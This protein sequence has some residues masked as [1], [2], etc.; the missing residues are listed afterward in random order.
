MFLLAA[1][2]E[3]NIELLATFLSPVRVGCRSRAVL[4]PSFAQSGKRFCCLHYG[5]L[6]LTVQL[7]WGED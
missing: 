7:C 3:L 2:M 1:L 4:T 5:V 6:H